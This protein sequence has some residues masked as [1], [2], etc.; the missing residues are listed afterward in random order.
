MNHDGDSVVI[1]MKKESSF[2]YP[3]V[4]E[5]DNLIIVILVDKKT[6]WKFIDA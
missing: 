5:T 6:I 1:L 2:L 3:D 4:S